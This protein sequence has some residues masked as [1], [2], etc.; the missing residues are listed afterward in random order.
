MVTEVYNVT[1]RARGTNYSVHLFCGEVLVQLKHRTGKGADYL[2]TRTS[3]G[4]L[5]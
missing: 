1:A 3:L 2:L 4:E 5:I